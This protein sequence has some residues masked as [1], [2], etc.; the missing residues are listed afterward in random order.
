[1]ILR[2]LRLRRDYPCRQLVE[3]VTDYLEG[4][5]PARERARLERHLKACEGC[6]AYVE[7]I[8]RTIELTGRLTEADVE[9]MA[10]EAREALL[11]AFRRAGAR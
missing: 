11:M 3:A 5:M 7:Q 4:T 1:M 9:A 8:R 10:P 2:R 6:E